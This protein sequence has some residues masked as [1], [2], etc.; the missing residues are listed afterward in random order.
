MIKQ[1]IPRI[2]E[3]CEAAGI[4]CRGYNPNEF[5]CNPCVL[6]KPRDD[7]RTKG[8]YCDKAGINCNESF[9]EFECGPCLDWS[10]KVK[11]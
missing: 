10:R 7:M 6:G 5:E 3:Y 2:G 9:D 8:H 11:R 4:Q 1:E